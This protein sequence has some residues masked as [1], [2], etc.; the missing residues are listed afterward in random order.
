M[1]QGGSHLDHRGRPEQAYV[2]SPPTSPYKCDDCGSHDGRCGASST[3]SLHAH[4]DGLAT[5]YS[6]FLHV[7]PPFHKSSISS[8]FPQQKT[9]KITR[10]CL[11]R[12][13]PPAIE[14]SS[15][16]SRFCEPVARRLQVGYRCLVRGLSSQLLTMAVSHWRE[17]GSSRRAISLSKAGRS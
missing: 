12:P 13:R 6:A 5:I 16:R 17:A 1:A 8:L 11:T 4:R 10:L 14:N 9:R 15:R 2:L 7:C 3:T